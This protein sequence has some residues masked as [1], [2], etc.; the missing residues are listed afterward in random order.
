MVWNSRFRVATL[1]SVLL[2]ALAIAVAACGG[3]DEG[4]TSGPAEEATSAEETTTETTSVPGRVDLVTP[5]GDELVFKPDSAT[6]TAGPVT[7]V[8]HNEST[9]LHSI[10]LED[11]QG[12][13][14]NSTGGTVCSSRV[15]ATSA[16]S[17]NLTE[18]YENLKPGK[19]TFYCGVDG[20][21]AQGMEGTL[22]V[23]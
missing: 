11:P 22:T 18:T 23:E 6:A 9:L 20:H 2:A 19:Y 17:G 7:V 4:T 15:K 12:E 21:R 5:P 16:M 14:I 3:G 13:G 10:C 1:V 8:W